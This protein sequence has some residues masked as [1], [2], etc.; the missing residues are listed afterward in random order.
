[1]ATPQVAGRFC[2]VPI[3]CN[4]YQ[5]A[6]DCLNYIGPHLADGAILVVDDWPH[7]RVYCEQRAFQEWQSTVPRLEFEFLFH[8]TIGHFSTPVHHKK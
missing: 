1:M 7:V 8:G 6:L 2:Y 4:I 5:P 3:Y